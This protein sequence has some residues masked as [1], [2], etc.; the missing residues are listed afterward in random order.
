VR[1][2]TVTSTYGFF[3]MGPFVVKAERRKRAGWL[4]DQYVTARAMYPE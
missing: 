3:P 2:R 4:M 1:L